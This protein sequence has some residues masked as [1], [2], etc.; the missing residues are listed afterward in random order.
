MPATSG[1]RLAEPSKHVLFMAQTCKE[2]SSHKLVRF[3]WFAK[4]L[5][6]KIS[7]SVW[8]QGYLRMI[9]VSI[10]LHVKKHRYF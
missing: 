6:H 10:Q 9:L 4:N 7:E 8:G 5:Y 3:T 1:V 2:V